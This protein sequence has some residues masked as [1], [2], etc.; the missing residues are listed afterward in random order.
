MHPFNLDVAR[1]IIDEI[2]RRAEAQMLA[3]QV[4]PSRRSLRDTVRRVW[5]TTF[6]TEDRPATPP[7]PGSTARLP[8][9][10]PLPAKPGSHRGGHTPKSPRRENNVTYAN[11]RALVDTE[12]LAA[13]VDDPSIA[14]IE[15]DEDTDA[16]NRGH[17]PGAVS[18]DWMEELRAKPHRD[19]LDAARLASLLASKGVSDD[20]HIVLYGGNNNWFAAYAYWLFT[21]RGI[22]RVSLLDGGRALWEAEDRPLTTDTPMPERGT[23]APT[24][25]RPHL[26]AFRDEVAARARALTGGMVDV[27]SPGEF[28]GEILAPPHLPGE[29]PYVPGHVPGAVNIPWSTAVDENGT[30]KSADALREIYAGAGIMPQQDVITYCRIGERSAHTWFVL[31]QLLGYDKVRNYDGS[32]TEY[33]SLVDVPVA[34]GEAA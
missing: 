24:T 11:P 18:L 3:A 20:Q 6:R 16:Y 12:W 33:G 17:L 9:R 10:Y 21:Y 13:H 23:F 15:V 5:S 26:R 4:R 31:S 29:H 7:G 27:R 28:S 22:D 34:V 25:Q 30:F 1:A 14:I 19:F 2:N 8:V 32:W